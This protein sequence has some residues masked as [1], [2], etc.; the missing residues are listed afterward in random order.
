MV[1]HR[2]TWFAPLQP[3]EYRTAM[4]IRHADP[5][6]RRYQRVLIGYLT[7]R[8]DDLVLDQT[9]EVLWPRS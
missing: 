7:W 5:P 2:V 8:H 3:A 6:R 1:G 4:A 9:Q